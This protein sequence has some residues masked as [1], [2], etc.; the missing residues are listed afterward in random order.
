MNPSWI[1]GHIPDD[2]YEKE[3]PGHLEEARRETEEVLSRQLERVRR[4]NNEDAED[5]TTDPQ[6][7]APPPLPGEP[8]QF[9]PTGRN[10]GGLIIS[11]GLLLVAGGAFLLRRAYRF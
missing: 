2:M 10:V 8:P 6:T 1:T 5:I 11:F 7:T 3:H 4:R 9:G